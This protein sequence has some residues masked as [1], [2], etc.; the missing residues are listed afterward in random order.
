MID[1]KNK[2]KK[3]MQVLHEIW[4]FLFTVKYFSNALI[5]ILLVVL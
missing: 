1:E 3:S 5:L 2:K 4:L